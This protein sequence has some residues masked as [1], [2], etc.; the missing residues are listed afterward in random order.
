[1]QKQYSITQHSYGKNQVH[2]TKVTRHNGQ[3]SLTE[4]TADVKLE[5]EFE[6]AY[7]D[8]DNRLIVPTD[9]MKNTLYVLAQKN[10]VPNLESFGCTV[11]NHFLDC[12]QHVTR[13]TIRLWQHLWTHIVVDGESH[14]HAFCGSGGECFT[15]VVSSDR[16]KLL[17]TSGIDRLAVL[18]TR[19]S[20]FQ[21]FLK[22]QYTTLEETE[23]R[24]LATT[25]TA[26][27]NY[28]GTHNDWPACRR[29]IRETLLE[30]FATHQ[31]RSVQH[32][33]Y[34]MASAALDVCDGLQSITL[35]MPNQ[36][37]ILVDL[38]PFGLVNDNEIFVPTAA[39]QGMIRATVNRGKVS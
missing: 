23:D 1:M 36:H 33:L 35:R 11:V 29:R 13:A 9:T 25:I 12:Y 22:D 21:N 26:D 20:G 16:A 24:I 7:M 5:G 27:W 4:L 2:L 39:P 30:V 31:S 32:T 10:G 17:I 28:R 18:K 38:E 34:A 8:G 3:D 15:S 19:D 14:P 6:S 37:R